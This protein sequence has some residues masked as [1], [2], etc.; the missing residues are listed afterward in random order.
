MQE[1]IE[2]FNKQIN[3]S[4]STNEYFCRWNNYRAEITE[5]ISGCMWKNGSI[6]M[7]GAGN[8]QDVDL[9]VLYNSSS[10]LILADIDISAVE[11]GLGLHGFSLKDMPVVKIDFGSL[12]SN[13]MINEISKHIAGK[14]HSGLLSCFDSYEF[15][16]GFEILNF[17]NVLISS[18]YTQL[19]LPQ[20]LTILKNADMI[21]SDMKR[22]I[23]P[24]LGFAARLISHVN[25][26]IIKFAA[27]DATVC[28]WSDILEYSN[29]DIALNDIKSH[30]DDKV[31][32]DEYY[33]A[34]I[35]NYGHGLGSFGI[36]ELAERLENVKEKW[37]I[38]PFNDSRTLIVKIISGIATS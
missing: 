13:E 12:D 33:M 31:W 30:I 3:E 24:A 10:E 20:F 36:S 1:S 27:D 7:L 29:D 19:F 35:M 25:D 32:M 8:I 37:L 9:K 17:D 23:E 18:I 2:K 11:K 28:A 38:W 22:F 4:A 26:L 21:Y 14:D 34:Y 6:V 5:F 16:T 15:S